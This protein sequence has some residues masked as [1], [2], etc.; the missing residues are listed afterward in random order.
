[1]NLLNFLRPK[2]RP[3][4]GVLEDSRLPE[5]KQKDYRTEEILPMVAP[6]NYRPWDDWRTDPK[7]IKRL[8]DIKVKNQNG[9]GSCAAQAG[10]THLEINNYLEDGKYTELS[11]RSI[12]GNRRNKPQVGTYMDDLGNILVKRGAIP[13]VFCPSPNDTEAHMSDVSDVISLYEGF[14]K[15]TRAG[16]YIWLT[17]KNID[18]YAR[19]STLDLPIAFTVKFGEH[20]W[21]NELCP[22]LRDIDLPYGHCN[23][24]FP[25][26]TVMYQGKKGLVDQDS[27]DKYVGYGGRR[28][29]TED[30]FTAGR[31]LFGIWT[32]DL[33]NLAIF[34]Q[35]VVEQKPHYHFTREL[36]VGM[37]GK[38][39]AML[40]VCLAT[41]QDADGFLFPL[42]QGQEPTG[43]YGGITRNAVQRFQTLYGINPVGRVGPETLAKLNEVFV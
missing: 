33:N 38:D 39:V 13:E 37:R 26:G 36:E 2:I 9:V 1:M 21:G 43:Y 10:A 34:N 22:Q 28:I 11:A 24:F 12:Y 18:D 42:W 5:E 16:S 3:I 35:Q 25:S 4:N 31:I 19:I 6:P 14:G 15:V 30:W 32:V 17:G 27:W 7:N 29:I 8:N 20:E 41:L 40:Q 23:D